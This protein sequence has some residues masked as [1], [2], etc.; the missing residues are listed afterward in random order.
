M[1]LTQALLWLIDSAWLF[2]SHVTGRSSFPKPLSPEKEREA[3]ERMAAGDGEAKRTL[4]EHNLRLV[5]HIVKKYAHTNLDQDDM[6][7]IGTIGLIKAVNSFKP[8]AGVQLATY[9][10]RCVE[11][12]VL[13]ALRSSKKL[14]NNVSLSDPIAS[15]REGNEILLMDVLG[16]EGDIVLDAVELSIESGRAIRLLDVVLTPR[17]RTVV[18]LRYGLLDGVC[19]P[20][21]QVAKALGISRSYVSRIEKRAIEK[22]RDALAEQAAGEE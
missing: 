21:H 8:A 11:N 6:V 13:M 10:A 19:Y 5:A 1:L 2:L 17:E 12:E 4:I 22:L 7:S 15:D 14:K 20:Q 3:I 9:A 16:T 18:V